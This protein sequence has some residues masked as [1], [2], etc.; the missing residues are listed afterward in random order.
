M[1]GFE[2]MYLI[3]IFLPLLQAWEFLHRFSKIVGQETLP[4]FKDLETRF[5]DMGFQAIG[6]QKLIMEIVIFCQN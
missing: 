5:S 1:H 3:N 6:C 4:T 2:A